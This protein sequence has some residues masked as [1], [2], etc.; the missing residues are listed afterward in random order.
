ML[1]MIL[2]K[3]PASLRGELS[4]WLLQPRPGIF[5]GGP[6]KR[7]RDELWAKA[8][9]KIKEGVVTQIW[10]ART[11]QGYLYRQ[12]GVNE[13][14]LLDFEGLGLVV[15]LKKNPK[16]KK[17]TSDNQKPTNP[18]QKESPPTEPPPEIEAPDENKET[19]W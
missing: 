10:T 9:K 6:S 17:A 15:R 3:S 12:H 14:I 18:E 1:V 7:I 8:C 13:Q 5:I 4:R 16:L 19:P 11:E 2:E